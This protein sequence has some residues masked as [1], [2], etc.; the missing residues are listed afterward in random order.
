MAVEVVDAV[1][2]PVAELDRMTALRSP[3]EVSVVRTTIDRRREGAVADDK[4]DGVRDCHSECCGRRG[5]E[6]TATGVGKSDLKTRR[7]LVR[8]KE[9]QD[10][11]ERE[12]GEYSRAE[13]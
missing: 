3:D 11:G 6:E 1:D 5:I 12:R 8:A 10:T 4:L 9:Q 2:E 13:H 7:L